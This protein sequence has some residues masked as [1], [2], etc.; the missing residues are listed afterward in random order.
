MSVFRIYVEKK[1][2]FTVEAQGI[3]NDLKTSLHLTGKKMSEF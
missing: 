1:K 2:P 3:L